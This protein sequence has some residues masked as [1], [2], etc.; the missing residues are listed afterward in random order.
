MRSSV[1]T[2]DDPTNWMLMNGMPP[3]A[4]QLLVVAEDEKARTALGALLEQEGFSVT[5]AATGEAALKRIRQAPPDAVLCNLDAL[6]QETASSLPA[7]M[8]SVATAA[9]IVVADRDVATPPQAAQREMCRYL[10]KPCQRQELIAAVR[11]ALAE[12]LVE[13]RAERPASPEP[14]AQADSAHSLH[15]LMGPSDWV[16]KLVAD[17]DRVAPTDFTVIIS[18]ETGSGKELAAREIHL[19]SRRA[20]GPFLAIDCGAVQPNLIE[21]ELF[22]HEK[23][24]FTGADRSR[25]G[26]FVAAS[27]GTVF[28]DEVQNLPPGVQTNL[29]RVLQERQVCP[30]G[31][32]RYVDFDVRV[33]TATNQNLPALV[34]AGRFRQDLYHRLNEFSI[35]VPPLR[36]RAE[37][38]LYLAERFM[39]QTCEE[40]GKNRQQISLEAIESMHRHAWP[41]NVR[42]LRNLIRRAVLLAD[43]QIHPEHLG[44]IGQHAP[45]E[46]QGALV[47]EITAQPIALKTLIRRKV[48]EAEREILTR[49]LQQTGGNKA[50][51]ARLLQIDYK[52]LRTKARQYGITMLLNKDMEKPSVK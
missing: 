41:G 35:E 25:I 28:L 6:S 5:K 11:Q 40:L 10:S 22:G 33:I 26:K 3:V 52:T 19:R 30:L 36:E 51:A 15:E 14:A 50:E 2:L 23:G 31:G 49:V 37:D 32:A 48:V 18:G 24:A 9:F 38:I 21:S 16:R 47:D 8:K 17:I 45:C 29:L 12:R 27:G 13:D 1:F 34:A 4:P 42:E 43:D 20:K 7:L 44:L 46:W 39:L